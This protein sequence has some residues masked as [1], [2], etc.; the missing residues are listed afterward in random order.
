KCC[1]NG[2]V[3]ITPEAES[4]S[5]VGD[6]TVT[7]HRAP[8]YFRFMIAGAVLGLVVALVLT[9]AFPEPPGFDYSQV[10]GFLALFFVVAGFALGA[11]VALLV[12]RASRRAAKTI[13]VELIEGGDAEAG[14]AEPISAEAGNAEPGG[15]EGTQAVRD[16]PQ[17]DEQP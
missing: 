10:F 12:D 7:I 5:V 17:G 15:A 9:L 2:G 14:S 11:I 13:S 1:E 8:R 6:D 3:S 4:E 16:A